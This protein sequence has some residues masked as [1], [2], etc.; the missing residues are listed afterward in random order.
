MRA[1]EMKGK[2]VAFIFIDVAPGKDMKVL[3]RL[4]KYDEVVEA[5][6]IAGQYDVL[7][8]L[9]FELFGSAIFTP[10][11]EVISKFVIEK[12]RKLGDVRDTNTIYPTFSLSKRE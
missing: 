6:L 1:H 9:E 10:S 12:I 8:V 11:Q 3:E 7:A 5:H 2:H 4:V